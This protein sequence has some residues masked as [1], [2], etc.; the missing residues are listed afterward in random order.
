MPDAREDVTTVNI[1]KEDA[2]FLIGKGGR[3]KRKL[4]RVSGCD[5]DLVNETTLAITG[6]RQKRQRAVK[7]VKFVTEQR[8]GTVKVDE[9][10]AEGE[11]CTVLPVPQEA[12]GFVTGKHGNFL[13]T[14][15]DEHNVIMFFAEVGDKNEEFEHLVIFGD[16]RGRRGAQLTVM[17]VV[18]TKLPRV[19]HSRLSGEWRDVRRE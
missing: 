15:E 3:T 9:D 10:D 7:Y 6:T 16:R 14:L 19:L 12:V 2:A 1:S 18:E 13:R 5:L 8:V 17:S 4:I 11:D